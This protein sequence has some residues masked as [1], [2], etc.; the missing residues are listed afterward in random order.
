MK[1]GFLGLFLFLILITPIHAEIFHEISLT[2]EE[3]IINS[4]LILNSK[5]KI[6][7]WNLK[8]NIPNNSEIIALKDEI[9]VVE[10][11]ISNNEINFVTNRKK[12]NTRIVNLIFKKKLE[13]KYG[14]K[15]A[16][17]S[18]FGFK[19]D[20][21]IITAPKVSYLFIPDAEIEYGETIKAKTNGGAILK[22][23]FNGKKESEHYF[24]DSDLDLEYLEKY[25][26]VIKGLTGMKVPVKFGIVSL[27]DSEYNE[28]L[29]DWSSGAFKDG[30]VF[31]RENLSDYEKTATILHETTHGF[32]SFA[33]DWDKTKTAWFDEG[34]ACYVT[35]VMYRLLNETKPEIFGEEIKWREGRTIH[36][37]KPNMEPRDLHN[38]YKQ[39]KNW[40]SAWYPSKHSNKYQ[41]EFGYA[42]SEL[43]I[44]DFLKEDG[45]NLH[46]IYQELLKINKSVE[47]E[48]VKNSMILKIFGR[49]LKPCYSTNFKEIETCVRELN[50]MDFNI[51]KTEGSEINCKIEIPKIPKEEPEIGFDIIREINGFF[52]FICKIISRYF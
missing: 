44:R 35:S 22:I 28:I 25:C 38:Y 9:G 31:V 43:F 32:N 3:I 37:L 12:A 36:T 41:R 1:T 47:N 23:V 42:Y 33:L 30:L 52:E 45:S 20:S 11:N 10:Y 5:D 29:E 34:V 50:E 27:P 26:W 6:D 16:K 19:N 4:T 14:F 17:I 18:L 7:Y 21:T 15:I 13:E 8:V 2:N 39:G 40:V 48:Y 24:T 49:E 51:P 46:R